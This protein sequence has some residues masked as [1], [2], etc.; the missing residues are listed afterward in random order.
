LGRASQTT[1]RF[2]SLIL[3]LRHNWTVIVTWMNSPVDGVLADHRHAPQTCASEAVTVTQPQS[4]ARGSSSL[5]PLASARLLGVLAPMQSRFSRLD[6]TLLRRGD[7]RAQ[8]RS[9]STGCREDPIFSGTGR[10]NYD[11]QKLREWRE[12]G[13][14]PCDA[15]SRSRERRRKTRR[16][17]TQALREW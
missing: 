3:R 11:R 15:L 12:R 4:T 6:M 14:S 7:L 5:H 16:K 2:S 17:C 10:E 8:Q 9:L 1:S 13:R